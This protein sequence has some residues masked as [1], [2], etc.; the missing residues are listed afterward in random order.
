VWIYVLAYTGGNG[1]WLRGFRV[2]GDVWL[3]VR[4]GMSFF[5][6]FELLNEDSEPVSFGE[7]RLP[8]APFGKVRITYEY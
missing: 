6:R 8:P 2:A 7:Q 3:E 5:R 1:G 4:G